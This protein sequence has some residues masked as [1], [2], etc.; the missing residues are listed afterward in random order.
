MCAVFVCPSFAAVSVNDPL[1]AES[2]VI[3]EIL[4]TLGLGENPPTPLEITRTSR[5]A[6]AESQ[7]SARHQVDRVRL[8]SGRPELQQEVAA[9]RVP[10]AT[11]V[12]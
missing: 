4:H 1:L 8:N 5:R 10:A 3:H 9:Y 11:K 7:P 6:A 12:S 2:L